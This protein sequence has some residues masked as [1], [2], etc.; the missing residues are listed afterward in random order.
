LFDLGRQ[1]CDAWIAQ[2][3]EV[4]GKRSTMDLQQLLRGGVFDHI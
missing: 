3:G 2:N 1:T 4:L